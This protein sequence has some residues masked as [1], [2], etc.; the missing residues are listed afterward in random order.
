MAVTLVATIKRFRGF[1]TDTKPSGPL[2]VGSEFKERD[3]GHRYE[4][5]GSW[6]WVRQEQT[7]DTMFAD[8]MDINREMLAVLRATHQG[9]EEYTWEETVEIEDDL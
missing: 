7:I 3:T 9:H 8:L 1:S 2:P 6:P 4:W 5:S